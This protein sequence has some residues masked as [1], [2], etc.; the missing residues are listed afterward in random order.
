MVKTNNNKPPTYSKLRASIG[1]FF[2][3]FQWQ[4]FIAA[5]VTVQL[6]HWP[7]G[8][9]K[10]EIRGRCQVPNLSQQVNRQKKS[11]TRKTFRAGLWSESHGGCGHTC[12]G[13]FASAY[14]VLV[15]AVHKSFSLSSPSLCWHHCLYSCMV[16]TVRD[17]DPVK[18]DPPEMD[19]FPLWFTS[20]A[21]DW[22]CWHGRGYNVGT[23]LCSWGEEKLLKGALS[24]T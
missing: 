19:Q 24:A 15:P 1:Y 13:R 16:N 20:E 11:F 18:N 5:R 8:K 6:S 3:E 21:H 2:E 4:F 10:A 12:I 23:R 9:I 7:W 14:L 17:L 22:F